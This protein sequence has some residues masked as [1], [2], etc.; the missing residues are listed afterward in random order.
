MPAERTRQRPAIRQFE[1]GDTPPE[2]EGASP[3]L[4]QSQAIANVA[5]EQAQQCARGDAAETKVRSRRN[6]SGQ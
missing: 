3:L 1:P 5:R 6:A 4:E 2:P